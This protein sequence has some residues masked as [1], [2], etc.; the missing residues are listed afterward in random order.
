YQFGKAGTHASPLDDKEMGKPIR[1]VTRTPPWHPTLPPE[2]RIVF[3][4]YR[5]LRDISQA[6]TR[7]MQRNIG[8]GWTAYLRPGNC[9]MFY[10]HSKS[11]Q[12]KTHEELERTLGRGDFF[13][14]FLSDYPT[15]HINHSVVVYAQKADRA[16][17]GAD[18]YLCYASTHH[19]GKRELKW[20][21]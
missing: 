2:Q 18:G 9:R 21:T 8:L 16:P 1:A 3:P 12:E 19:D 13:V 6:R 10:L 15:L 14:A 17:D 20:I 11:Y 4:G 5:D 7:L